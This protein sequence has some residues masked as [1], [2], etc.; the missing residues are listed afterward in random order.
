[1]DGLVGGSDRTETPQGSPLSWPWPW[2]FLRSRP[3]HSCELG[4]VRDAEQERRRGGVG[5]RSS[6]P[7]EEGALQ[8]GRRVTKEVTDGEVRT[9][10]VL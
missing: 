1:M 5:R 3:P 7:G 2:S 6:V 10:G 9:A 4:A 8:E